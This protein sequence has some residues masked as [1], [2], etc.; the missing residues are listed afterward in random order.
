MVGHFLEEKAKAKTRFNRLAAL[1]NFINGTWQTN[2]QNVGSIPTNSTKT[3]VLA[4]LEKATECQSVFEKN[5]LP[6]LPFLKLYRA[7]DQLTCNRSLRGG[8]QSLQR[9]FS[10]V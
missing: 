1:L 8:H 6:D 3:G 4:K 10:V 7:L 2:M 9:L 5:V